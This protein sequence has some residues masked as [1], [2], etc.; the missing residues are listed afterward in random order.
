MQPPVSATPLLGVCR[1]CDLARHICPCDVNVD[2][3][4]QSPRPRPQSRSFIRHQIAAAVDVVLSTSHTRATTMLASDEVMAEASGASV[5][6]TTATA[7][8][9]VS[10]AATEAEAEAVEV[11]AEAATAAVEAEAEAEAAAEAAAA[12]PT[13]STERGGDVREEK[14]AEEPEG[15]EASAS[16]VAADIEHAA[17]MADLASQS[18]QLQLRRGS[19]MGTLKLI[20]SLVAIFCRSSIDPDAARMLGLSDEDVT[21]PRVCG[22]YLLS[23]FEC[24]PLADAV[25]ASQTPQKAARK[26]FEL[27]DE[28]IRVLAD[29]WRTTETETGTATCDRDTPGVCRAVLFPQPAKRRGVKRRHPTD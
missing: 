27:R 24:A 1:R 26:A 3:A 19:K 8:A 25:L 6:A 13:P 28:D 9:T 17:L 18:A 11:I 16:V 5:E 23:G 22:Y 21:P 10:K 20:R 15:E 4:P 12:T 2:V 7:T 14:G 29:R